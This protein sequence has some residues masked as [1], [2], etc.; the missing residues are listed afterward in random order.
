VSQLV[1]VRHAQA[2]LFAD[3]YDVLSPLGEEQAR[4]LGR[5]WAARRV[6]FDEVYVG[7]MRRQRQTADLVT[8]ALAEVGLAW[9]APVVLAGLDEYDAFGIMREAVPVLRER[10]PAIRSLAERWDGATG[11]AD[12][13]RHYQ[14]LFEAVM[15][16]WL[17]GRFDAP[18]IESWRSFYERASRAW[19][20]IAAREGSGRRVV[21]FSSGGPI[22]VA[23]QMATRGPEATAIDLSWRIRNTSLT[24]IVFTRDRFSLDCFNT[25]PHLDDPALWTYR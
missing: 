9:P 5:Y 4:Q 14:R 15:A 13:Y 16:Y 8:G 20:S 6:G 22:G 11:D 19:Q 25:L 2:S 7:T 21:A 10:D 18:G 23:V 1:L 3:D 17:D 24:E 12:R